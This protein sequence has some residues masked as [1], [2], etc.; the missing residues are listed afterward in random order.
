MIKTAPSSLLAEAVSIAKELRHDLHRHPELMY[1]EFRTAEQVSK[2]LTQF[3]IE[4]KTGLAGGTGVLGYLPATTKKPEQAE[5]IAL[6]ADMDALP[7]LENTGVPYTSQTPGVMHACGHDGHTAILV[8]T[9]K[10]LKESERDR[11]VLFIFQP[12]EEGGAGGKR[13]CEDGVLDGSVLGTKAD[14]IFGL[15]CASM[16]ALGSASSRV[17]PMMAS[18]DEFTIVVRGKGGHAAS[19]QHSNDPI[20]VAAYILTALQ[21]IASRN[22]DPLESVV[23]TVGKIEAGAVSNV[24]PTSAMMLGTIRTLQADV[25]ELAVKRVEEIATQIASAFG[26]TVEF[27]HKVG[28]PVTINDEGAHARVAT[29]ATSLMG[30][31]W[32]EYPPVMGGEDFSFYGHHVPA[33]FYWLGIAPDGENY[34][35]V[36]TP[37]F[38]FNDDAI[39]VGIEMMSQLALIG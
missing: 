11:N 28:Y 23:V 35:G 27:K 1:Q 37:E 10:L 26:A 14:V 24:I 20:V 16:V 4:H 17:G 22:V 5:T 8:G 6:R 34:P 30:E 2:H 33:C 18:T 39:P 31:N 21:T 25:R 38:D 32:G 15:H 7:I 9:A 12:A 36:H 29:V 13:M 19:P 3:G